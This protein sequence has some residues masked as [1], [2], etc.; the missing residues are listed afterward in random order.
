LNG[1]SP[2]SFSR[3]AILIGQKLVSEAPTVNLEKA[4]NHRFSRP[5]S[6]PPPNP[7]C[8]LALPLAVGVGCPT[9]SD[10]RERLPTPTARGRANLP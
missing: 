6:P 8:A 9:G 2:L 1:K 4:R 3:F 7:E 5:E 10:R